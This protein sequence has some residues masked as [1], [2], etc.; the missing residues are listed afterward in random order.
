[1]SH[2]CGLQFHR[3]SFSRAATLRGFL[4]PRPGGIG[5]LRH[6]HQ[7]RL[8]SIRTQRCLPLPLPEFGQLSLTGGQGGADH[9][10]RLGGR[11]EFRQAVLEFLKRSTVLVAEIR[12][13]PLAIR[14]PP[15]QAKHFGPQEKEVQQPLDHHSKQKG[16]KERAPRMLAN[17]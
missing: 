16:D 7:L 14:Q 6:H 15:P 3:S 17:Q 13:I 10:L 8:G 5:L 12:Q 11:I 4:H 9:H 1:M 2:E